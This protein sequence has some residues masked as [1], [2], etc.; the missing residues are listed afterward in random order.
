[1]E[2][3][4]CDEDKIPI[5]HWNTPTVHGLHMEWSERDGSY[6]LAK[7]LGCHANS[8]DAVSQLFYLH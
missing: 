8:L 5:Q 1:V 4:R 3:G 7:L 2:L 6:V